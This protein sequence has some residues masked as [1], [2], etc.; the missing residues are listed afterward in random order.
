MRLTDLLTPARVSV[1]AVADGAMNKAAAIRRLATMLADGSGLDADRVENVLREREDRQ[2]TG[3]GEGVAIPHGFPDGLR[4]QVGALI[5]VRAGV[6]FDAID[7]KDVTI[8]LAVI[9]PKSAAGDHLKTLAR[10][11][12]VLRSAAFRERLLAASTPLAAYD[13]LVSEEEAVIR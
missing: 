2:S 12:R 1:Q 5:T 8:L 6:P 3:I 10:I 9:C 4:E 11:S 13:A 7:G